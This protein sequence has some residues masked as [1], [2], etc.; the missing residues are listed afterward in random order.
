MRVLGPVVEGE[1]A[2]DGDLDG[3]A[4]VLAVVVETTEAQGKVFYRN[5]RLIAGDEE[6]WHENARARTHTPRKQEKGIGWGRVST[7][8]TPE[9]RSGRSS[10]SRPASQAHSLSPLHESGQTRGRGGRKTREFAR[11]SV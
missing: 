5:A 6:D 9:P 2:V 4:E 8:G 1:G 3:G 10:N 7:A 11:S